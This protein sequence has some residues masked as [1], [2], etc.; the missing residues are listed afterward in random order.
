M[1]NTTPKRVVRPENYGQEGGN[2]GWVG[3][4]THVFENTAHQG[5]HEGE[6]Q[7]IDILN[8]IETELSGSHPLVTDPN[9]KEHGS[10]V[11]KYEKM[12]KTGFEDDDG[13]VKVEAG[14]RAKDRI[15][16]TVISSKSNSADLKD[17]KKKI[18]D[19]IKKG[20]NEVETRKGLDDSI[21]DNTTNPGYQDI[22]LYFQLKV[23]TNISKNHYLKNERF[24]IILVTAVTYA[25]KSG[26]EKLKKIINRSKK[27]NI[28]QFND[29]LF[30]GTFKNIGGEG[31]KFYK[32]D[33]VPRVKEYKDWHNDFPKYYYKY[34]RDNE[35]TA[36]K[37][38]LVSTLKVHKERIEDADPALVSGYYKR[39]MKEKI[40]KM[41]L[42]L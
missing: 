10:M 34:F 21:K 22:K 2:K 40:D 27:V 35:K 9:V 16:A 7:M 30:V 15:R 24:E 3:A 39:L 1:L 6:K 36:D 37:L 19:L 13:L 14:Y 25:A 33:A 5:Q 42:D 17:L 4:M 26:S 12:I 11:N 18:I 31:H 41:L 32:M 29:K 28:G 23:P 38:A 20:G 8:K